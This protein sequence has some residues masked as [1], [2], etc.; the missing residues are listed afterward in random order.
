[1]EILRIE[2]PQKYGYLFK[3]GDFEKFFD[4]SI[5]GD[6]H[7][8]LIHL[9]TYLVNAPKLF[10]DRVIFQSEEFIN[11]YNKLQ[12]ELKLED[13]IQ[14]NE[15]RIKSI[16]LRIKIKSGIKTSFWELI[17]IDQNGITHSF[18][19][20]VNIFASKTDVIKHFNLKYNLNL[21]L[22]E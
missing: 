12:D 10:P 2:E 16:T 13:F 3:C 6:K 15:L 21:T 7:K 14:F 18:D 22:T 8:S 1:M 19:Y 11:F 4:D 9:K 5:T 17:I 20:D